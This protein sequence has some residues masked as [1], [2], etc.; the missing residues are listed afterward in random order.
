M[1]ALGF[2][3]FTLVIF[4]SQGD[5]FQGLFYFDSQS[6]V[7]SEIES[8]VDVEIDGSLPV[9]LS[10]SRSLVS[11]FRVNV[12]E[13]G[14]P[15]L[16]GVFELKAFEGVEKI[17]LER[18]VLNMAARQFDFVPKKAALF[19]AFNP[20][21][22]EVDKGLCDL[23]PAPFAVFDPVKTILNPDNSLDKVVEF[24]V[25]EGGEIDLNDA[26]YEEL[27]R[28]YFLAVYADLDAP[29]SQNDVDAVMTGVKF[30]GDEGKTY[31]VEGIPTAYSVINSY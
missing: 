25:S 19:F 8:G 4:S 23:P 28:S 13:D 17:N 14:N 26:R 18:L 30:L 10:L 31:Q 7:I 24:V 16:V 11:P 5:L 3:V 9:K 22:Y 20:T 12:E 15:V 2:L 1:F 6:P 29:L 21:C 27:G